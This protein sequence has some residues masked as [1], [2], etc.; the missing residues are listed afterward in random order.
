MLVITRRREESFRVSGPARITIVDFN[1][2]KVKI[3]ID[4]APEVMIERD[5]MI[6]CSPKHK[7]ESHEDEI[8]T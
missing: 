1:N 8:K 3:G 4:A 2:V 6:D 7:K 5:D